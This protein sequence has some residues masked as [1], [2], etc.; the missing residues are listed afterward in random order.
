MRVHATYVHFGTTFMFR[1]FRV[2]D[3]AKKNISTIIKMDRNVTLMFFGNSPDNTSSRASDSLL[4]DAELDSAFAERGSFWMLS[5]ST[6]NDTSSFRFQFL[7]H[8]LSFHY[9][10]Q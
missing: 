8:M 6:L 4:I 7:A 5:T 2:R 1:F 9:V 10:L 3:Q